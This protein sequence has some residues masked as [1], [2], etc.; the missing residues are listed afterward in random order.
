MATP[1]L[2]DAQW[3]RAAWIP[4]CRIGP[5]ATTASSTAGSCAATAVAGVSNAPSA[6]CSA[7]AASRSAT[8]TGFEQHWSPEQIAGWGRETGELTISH[9]TIYRDL[10]ADRLAGGW[11]AVPAAAPRRP[12]ATP[13][14]QLTQRDCTRIAWQGNRRP[15]K[16][17]GVRTPEDCYVCRISCTS[18]LNSL[19]RRG[20]PPEA[21]EA[22]SEQDGSDAEP[23]LPDQ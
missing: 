14:A 15:R 7:S 1:L 9:E 11:G 19:P 5:P 18:E 3:A 20:V 22:E 8:G 16:R 13:Q 17:L 12:A 21:A 23:D 2:A 6:C 10:G 4:S